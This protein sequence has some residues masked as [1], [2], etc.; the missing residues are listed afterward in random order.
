[1]WDQA[2]A[3]KPCNIECIVAVSVLECDVYPEL[4]R[5]ARG[6]RTLDLAPRSEQAKPSKQL[7]E[8]C[9]SVYKRSHL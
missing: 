4:F 3:L 6:L 5:S 1:M 7:W 2:S 8:E 9:E